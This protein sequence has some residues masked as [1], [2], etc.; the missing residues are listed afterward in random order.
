M[1]CWDGGMRDAAL[2]RYRDAVL[3]R[4]YLT[5]LGYGIVYVDSMCWVEDVCLF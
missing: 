5:R 3:N 1:G 4:G 2:D